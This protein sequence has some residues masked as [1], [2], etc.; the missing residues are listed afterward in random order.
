MEDNM[1]IE[2]GEEVGTEESE[3]FADSTEE[4]VE[5]ISEDFEILESETFEASDGYEL[6]VVSVPED[7]AFVESGVEVTENDADIIDAI[8]DYEEAATPEP[9]SSEVVSEGA[10][11]QAGNN[12]VAEIGSGV[13]SSDSSLESET[14]SFYQS[15]L[16]F[17]STESITLDDLH[18]EVQQLNANVEVLNSNIVAL[19]KNQDLYSKYLIGVCFA[20][21]GA[22]LIY[23]AFSKFS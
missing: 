16:E 20:I 2:V 18:T 9:I 3:T 11:K 10:A 4:A 22:F 12:D 21:F 17:F 13:A 14:S 6:A 15:V 19:S 7:I 8:D 23:V 1:L 5:D